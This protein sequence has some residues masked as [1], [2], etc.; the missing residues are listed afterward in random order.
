MR[1][2][3]SSGLAIFVLAIG[4]GPANADISGMLK[5]CAN[6]HGDNGVSAQEA[7][8]TIGGIDAEYQENALRAYRDGSR[9]CGDTPMMCKAAKR[10]SDD[11]IEELSHHYGDMPYVATAQDFDAALAEKG[12]A[13]HDASGCGMCHGDTPDDAVSAI[14]HGQK[15]AYLSAALKAYAADERDQ[16]RPMA[17]ALKAMSPEELEALTNYYSSYS[18]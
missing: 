13:I 10:L 14:L 6:C 5:M 2:M 17:K 16:P 7:T 8:P 9:G 18:P 15:K 3:I 1:R 4:T 11:Q 12:K